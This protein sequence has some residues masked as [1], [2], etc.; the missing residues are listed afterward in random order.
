VLC[1]EHR[2]DFATVALSGGVVLKNLDGM[3]KLCLGN[4]EY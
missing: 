1:Q 3:I 2:V 4:L